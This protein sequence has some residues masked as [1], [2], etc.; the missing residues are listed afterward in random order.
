MNAQRRRFTLSTLAAA[1]LLVVSSLPLAGQDYN[2]NSQP[3][4]PPPNDQQ[5]QPPPPPNA[6]MPNQ[7]QD[8]YATLPPLDQLVSPIALYPDPLIGLVLPASTEPW[9]VQRAASYLNAGWQP[10]QLASQPWS[11]PVKDLAHYQTV[12]QWMAN[13][14]QWTQQLGAAFAS[15]PQQ[16][17]NAIQDLRHR[18]L[19]AGTL[20]SNAQIQVV[21]DNG[22][23]RILP[24]QTQVLYVPQYNPY[25]VYFAGDPDGYIAWSTPYPCG[26]WLGYYPNWYGGGIYVGDWYHYSL[27]HGGWGAH[28]AIG[29]VGIHIGGWGGGF[30]GDFRA[31]HPA[32]G[33]EAFRY[34]W[35]A[36][37]GFAMAHPRMYPGAPGH[38]RFYQNRGNVRVQ[39]HYDE[40]NR[41]PGD[42]R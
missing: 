12:L 7:G 33:A 38:D 30:G 34:H 41:F 39:G 6:P 17:M 37:P 35:D 4:P 2:A 22:D 42:G 25:D 26:P 11:Q 29:G 40:R 36:R 24:A 10:D 19:A 15:Q 28:F 14:V 1:G 13:N 16:V 18:A 20:Q 8:Q 3:P 23:V 27:H 31:W 21:Q 5:G 32:P 9:Q